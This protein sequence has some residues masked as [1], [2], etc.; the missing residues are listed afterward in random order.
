MKFKIDDTYLLHCFRELVGVPSPSGYAKRL[1]PVLAR[2]A[3]ELGYSG[4]RVNAVSPG[5]IDTKMNACFS[6]EEKALL[7]EEIPLGRMGSGDEVASAV[8]F[9]EENEYIT[10]VDIPV[11]GGFSI[12]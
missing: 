1:S 8:L 4:V 2:Y 11:N 5:V 7:C 12:T 3:A 6:K 9:L 10:G